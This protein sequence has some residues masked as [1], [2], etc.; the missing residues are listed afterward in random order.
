MNL[1]YPESMEPTEKFDSGGVEGKMID[2]F[3]WRG[4]R[5]IFAVFWDFKLRMWY[6]CGICPKFSLEYPW[7]HKLV[8]WAFLKKNFS[9]FISIGLRG[10]SLDWHTIWARL[11]SMNGAPHQCSSCPMR[12]DK[13]YMIWENAGWILCSIERSWEVLYAEFNQHSVKF[14]QVWY[15]MINARGFVWLAMC[16]YLMSRNS[17]IHF[18]MEVNL[19]LI[20]VEKKCFEL[21]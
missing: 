2:S 8:A 21:R 13:H 14:C 12:F 11:T 3:L 20:W 5:K 4:F 17:C 15:L 7:K 18:F 9:S 1:F 10:A 16:S 6:F 19:H